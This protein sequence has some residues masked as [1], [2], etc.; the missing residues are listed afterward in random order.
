MSQ[1]QIPISGKILFATGDL[2]LWADITVLLKDAAGN[3]QSQTFRIDSATEITTFLAHKAKQLGLPL[4]TQQVRGVVHAQTGLEIRSGY[5]WFRVV[6][7]DATEYVT[8]CRFLGDPDTPAFGQ[9]VALPRKLIQP[10]GLRDKLRFILDKDLS[11]GTP[12]GT[13]T[14]QKE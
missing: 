12:Y 10:L 13:I 5:L 7:L 11:D 6:G 1:L 4:P 9:S 3:W 2:K 14:I 8:A